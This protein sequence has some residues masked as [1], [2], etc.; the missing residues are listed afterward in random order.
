VPTVVLRTTRSDNLIEPVFDPALGVRATNK[1][2]NGQGGDPLARPT[3][4]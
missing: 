2:W 4:P 1:L 3:T